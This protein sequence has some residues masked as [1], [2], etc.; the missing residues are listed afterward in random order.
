M[1]YSFLKSFVVSLTLSIE[2]DIPQ[3]KGFVCS[4][5]SCETSTGL[6]IE[7][8]FFTCESLGVSA[9]V[10]MEK[11]ASCDVVKRTTQLLIDNFDA[12]CVER[13]LFV[14]DGKVE[15]NNSMKEMA[16]MVLERAH[17]PGLFD[18]KLD[19]WHVKKNAKKSLSNY[20]TTLVP[21]VSGGHAKYGQMTAAKC[22]VFKGDVMVAI[23]TTAQMARAATL[24]A[25]E[26]ASASV[27]MQMWM[28]KMDALVGAQEPEFTEPLS[29]V[30]FE[31]TRNF[32][33]PHAID[34]VGA[35]ATSV[36]ESYHS[37]LDRCGISKSVHMRKLDNFSVFALI[38]TCRWN[39]FRLARELKRRDSVAD[40]VASKS[41]A[42]ERFVALLTSEVAD[43]RRARHVFDVMVLDALRAD[44][45]PADSLLVA[46]RTAFGSSSGDDVDE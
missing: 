5:T 19:A 13:F 22:D 10:Q 27:F 43:Q 29:N 31:F 46:M 7:Q 3:K 21:K 33:E 39:L 2:F 40:R 25:T 12:A 11:P 14:S 36:L 32:V 30:M 9:A 15:V 44:G 28:T 26:E 1:E 45:A 34:F 41:P 16:R 24:A 8:R 20:M 42:H 35:H 4:L 38:H 17:V 37:S 6:V 23:E 18:W